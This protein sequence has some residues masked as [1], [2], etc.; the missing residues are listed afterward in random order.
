MTAII[1]TQN[2]SKD[3][4]AGRGIKNLTMEVPEKSIFG[5]I[6][7]NGSGK[8]TTIKCLCGLIIPSSGRGWIDGLEV[9]PKN[10][11]QIKAKIGYLPDEFGV[12]EQMSVWEYLDFF[13]AAYKIRPT[14][15]KQR[16]YEVLELTDSSH[17]IDYQVSSLSRGMH[18]KI[19]IAKT[20]LHDP[21][22]LILDEPANGLDPHARI[23][24]R[25]TILRLKEIGKTIMLSSHILPE[26]GAICDRVAIIEKAELL[27]QGTVKEITRSLQEKI[28][29]L[30]EVDS[31]IDTAVKACK[32]FDNVEDAL[33]SANEIRVDYRGN[34]TQIA[35]L[36]SH[37]VNSGVRVQSISEMEVDLENVFLT[38]TG[39]HEQRQDAEV[40][41][42]DT[43]TNDARDRMIDKM[44]KEK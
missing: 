30:I 13:G 35:D 24:M 40:S 21:K 3:Y 8:T 19:G 27:I 36:N 23:E 12:Y 42:E 31:D 29:L 14:Q 9:L 10:I 43:A 20:M 25:K 38:V 11:Q 1:N 22:V 33:V 5:F 39:K 32:D 26:L 15:R 41:D 7:P 2:L 34:R 37:L 6:G 17:M 16:I 44:N 18:Q 4:G 28:Q